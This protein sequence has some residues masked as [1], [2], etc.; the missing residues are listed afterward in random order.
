MW[1][2]GKL[3]TWL[4]RNVSKEMVGVC[5]ATYSHKWLKITPRQWLEWKSPHGPFDRINKRI[6]GTTCFPSCNGFNRVL[7]QLLSNYKIYLFAFCFIDI[8]DI[9]LIIQSDIWFYVWCTKLDRNGYKHTVDTMYHS[10]FENERH[11]I[12]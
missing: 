2:F 10:L 12:K 4:A 1:L 6:V 7:S 8:W 5:H 11:T 3:L 9:N